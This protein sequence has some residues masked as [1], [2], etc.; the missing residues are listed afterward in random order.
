V[1]ELKHADQVHAQEAPQHSVAD[2]LP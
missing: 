1:P 2:H